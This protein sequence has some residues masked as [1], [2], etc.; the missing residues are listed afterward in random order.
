MIINYDPNIVLP[1]GLATPIR[2]QPHRSTYEEG[3]YELPDD[4]EEGV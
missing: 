1:D 4:E 3:R 2:I